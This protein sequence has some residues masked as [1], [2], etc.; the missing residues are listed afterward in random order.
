MDSE[1]S[2]AKEHS[3]SPS[4]NCRAP[5]SP[6]FELDLFTLRFQELPLLREKLLGSVS[7]HVPANNRTG[8]LSWLRA[9]YC[10]FYYFGTRSQST[11]NGDEKQGISQQKWIDIAAGNLPVEPITLWSK[12]N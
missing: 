2:F 11:M 4:L 10:R 7:I 5:S 1:S 6:F 3:Y 12:E 9:N 8:L